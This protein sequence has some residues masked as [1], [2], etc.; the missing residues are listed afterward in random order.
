MGM[1]AHLLVLLT[2]SMV[3]EQ[4]SGILYMCK[5]MHQNITFA[6]NVTSLTLHVYNTVLSEF[7]TCPIQVCKN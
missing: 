3:S 2:I 6:Q 1:S 7:R 5:H 4:K